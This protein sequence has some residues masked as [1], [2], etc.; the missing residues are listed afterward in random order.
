M[1]ARENDD[2]QRLRRRHRPVQAEIQHGLT[3]GQPLGGRG[4]QGL[5]LR[6]IVGRTEV[7]DRA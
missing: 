5:Q 1:A 6:L 7:L 3:F 2:L 4:L